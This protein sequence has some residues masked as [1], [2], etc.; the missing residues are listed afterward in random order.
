MFEGK[1]LKKYKSIHGY[2]VDIKE[3]ED[4]ISM[5]KSKQ[6]KKYETLKEK[7]FARQRGICDFCRWNIKEDEKTHIHHER[8]ISKGG[9]RSNLKNMVLVHNECHISHHKMID[10]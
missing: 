1:I 7:L 4:Y 8:L 10:K 9:S 3:L 6:N 5:Q 2:H